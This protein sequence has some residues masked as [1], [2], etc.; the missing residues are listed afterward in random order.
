MVTSIEQVMYHKGMTSNSGRMELDN[1][2]VRYIKYKGQSQ[3]RAGLI[4]WLIVKISRA[5]RKD[6]MLFELLLKDIESVEFI[7]EK[8]SSKYSE[9]EIKDRDNT[10]RISLGIGMENQGQEFVNQVKEELLNR[11]LM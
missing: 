1:K 4:V 9:I 3:G 10:H 11:G 5:F 2:A 8:S 7:H 6:K